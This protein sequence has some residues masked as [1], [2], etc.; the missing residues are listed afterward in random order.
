[1]PLKTAEEDE[2]EEGATASVVSAKETSMGAAVAAVLTELIFPIKEEQRTAL[3]AFP[4][5]QD[6]PALLRTGFGKSLV[7]HSSALQLVMWW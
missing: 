1:M 7:K 4:R 3:K 2:N 5:G 6:V